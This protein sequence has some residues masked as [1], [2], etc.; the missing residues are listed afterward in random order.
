MVEIN[1]VKYMNILML[2]IISKMISMIYKAMSSE[3]ILL[4]IKESL[5]WRVYIYIF[6]NSKNEIIF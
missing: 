5:V 4:N 3:F 2:Y 1:D 6:L